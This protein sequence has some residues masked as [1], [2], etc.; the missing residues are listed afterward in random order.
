MC[1]F[2]LSQ[3]QNRSQKR[4]NPLQ[5]NPVFFVE[6]GQAVAVD[7]Q[8]GGDSAV[9]TMDRN[10]DLAA[11]GAAAGDMPGEL[12]HVRDD[13]GLIPLP[14]RTADPFTERDVHARD[15]A[16]ERAENEFISRDPVE[17]G[18]PES[19]RFVQDGGDIRHLRDGVRLPFQQG[20]D[21]PLQQA[22]I[23][24]LFRYNKKVKW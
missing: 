18:P 6:S 2:L 8:D 4:H 11:G 3:K 16:L 12:F 1:R 17:T 14:G 13:D 7:V 19:K 9:G 15:R 20:G 22:V 24:G 5:P 21:L 10:D 23:F